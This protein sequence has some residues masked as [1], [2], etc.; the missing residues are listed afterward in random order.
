VLGWHRVHTWR[1]WWMMLA[2]VSVI[3]GDCDVC[4]LVLRFSVAAYTSV[5]QYFVCCLYLYVFCVWCVPLLCV[6]NLSI[7]CFI[8]V[9]SAKLDRVEE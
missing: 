4:E 7:Y 3:R 8:C 1:H 5:S 9:H 6:Y 2:L